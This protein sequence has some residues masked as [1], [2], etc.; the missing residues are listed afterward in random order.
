MSPLPAIDF[1]GLDHCPSG[2]ISRSSLVPFVTIFG[3]R[4]FAVGLAKLAL[5]SKSMYRAMGTILI[6]CTVSSVVDTVVMSLW[7]M[8]GKAMGHRR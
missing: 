6:C 3:G 7:S 2:D 5:H 1:F 8:D 4:N